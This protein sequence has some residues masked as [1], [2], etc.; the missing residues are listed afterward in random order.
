MME[1][2]YEHLT[3]NELFEKVDLLD[4]NEIVIHTGCPC[5]GQTELVF[6]VV[7]KDGTFVLTDNGQTLEHM[8]T[9]FE[10]TEPDVVKNVKAAT[11]YYGIGVKKMK[12][13]LPMNLKGDFAEAY[14]KMLFCVGFLRSMKLFY[15]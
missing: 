13:E 9:I 2:L 6:H 4:G 8:D 10:L 5:D 14:L 11:N 1:K 7:D 15:V 12:L 3:K